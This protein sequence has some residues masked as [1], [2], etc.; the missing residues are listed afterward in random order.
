MQCQKLSWFLVAAYVLAV[1]F[2]TYQ[3]YRIRTWV[4]AD[5][6]I[7]EINKPRTFREN[8]FNF[9]FNQDCVVRYTYVFAGQSYEGTRVWILGLTKQVANRY[10]LHKALWDAHNAGSTVPVFVNPTNPSKAI[11]DRRWPWLSMLVTGI[12]VAGIFDVVN[13]FKI[14]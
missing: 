7:V 12:V 5:A 4:E 3:W 9:E 1:I 6:S 14:L 10:R 2:K 13:H 8:G 11:L